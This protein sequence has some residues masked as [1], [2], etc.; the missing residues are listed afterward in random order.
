[1]AKRKSRSSRR[2]TSVDKL[3]GREFTPDYSYVIQDLKRIL[4]LAA[5]FITLLIVLSFILN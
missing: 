1:M 5:S 3:R 2:P 4:V